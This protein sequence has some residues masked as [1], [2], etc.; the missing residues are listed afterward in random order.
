MKDIDKIGLKEEDQPRTVEQLLL[1]HNKKIESGN[2]DCFE[3]SSD[4][5]REVEWED[6]LS[7]LIF[8]GQNSATHILIF[9]KKSQ[10]TVFTNYSGYIERSSIPVIMP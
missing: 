5:L 8:K 2:F 3:T 4:N 10:F 7:H 9:K 1:A 6:P